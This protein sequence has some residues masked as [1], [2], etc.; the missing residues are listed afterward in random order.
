MKKQSTESSF[1][2]SPVAE[3]VR[4]RKSQAAIET[5]FRLT[6]NREMNE[7]ERKMFGI[8]SRDGHHGDESAQS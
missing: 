8:T 5:V 2:T 6:H 4:D 7:A 1:R 3:Q